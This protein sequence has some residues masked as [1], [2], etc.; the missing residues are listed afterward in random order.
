MM[1][2]RRKAPRFN[3]GREAMLHPPGGGVGARAVVHLISTLGC[4]IECEASPALGKRC[5]LY[6]DAESGQIGV[7]AQ[8]VSKDAQ[9]RTGL[10]F[11]SVDKDSAKRLNE[12][13]AAL[14]LQPVSPAGQEPAPA[15]AAAQ[16]PVHAAPVP[17]KPAVDPAIARE[18][19][20]RRVPRYI[21]ELRASMSAVSA[22]VI[23]EVALITLSVL[24]C[25]L[26]GQSLPDPGVF[27]DVNADWEGRTLRLPGEVV[28]SKNKQIGIRFESLGEETERL[29]RQVC[30]SL[31]L[32]PLAPL[33]P[34]P[35]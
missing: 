12:L 3:F 31:R 16:E 11:L 26:E 27:C 20:R 19:E 28:W 18:R 10:K 2:E 14:Q 8:A 25:C 15:T 5:E 17:A 6:F 32:Q 13:C 30:A 7:E 9:G 23:S 1:R 29:L 22:E 34:E 21:S 35:E 33:P 24:G 4:A